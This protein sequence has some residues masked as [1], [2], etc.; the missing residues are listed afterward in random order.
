MQYEYAVEWDDGQVHQALC[1]TLD[2]AKNL[3]RRKSS[4]NL[5]DIFYVLALDR[6]GNANGHIA[7]SCGR[8]FEKLGSLAKAEAV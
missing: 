4:A 2:Q 6:E 5:D 7:Y 8:Q 3:A 1:D